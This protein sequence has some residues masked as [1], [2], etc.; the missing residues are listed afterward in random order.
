MLLRRGIRSTAFRSLT[1][2]TR[3][4]PR[5]TCVVPFLGMCTTPG[6]SSCLVMSMGKK[7]RGT[8]VDRGIGSDSAIFSFGGAR[9][10]VGSD[11][12]IGPRGTARLL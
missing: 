11:F 9:R 3:G 10:S 12:R 6:T 4:T 2:L 5:T 8:I 1:S 7:C